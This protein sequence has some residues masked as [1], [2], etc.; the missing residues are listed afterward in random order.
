MRQEVVLV[1]EFDQPIGR[2]EKQQAHID[3]AL[4]RA[5]SIFIFN[6]AGQLLLQQRALHK[7]HSAGLWSNSCCSHPQ[8]DQP[9][10]E[11]ADQR[12]QEEMG[13]R[14]ELHK[15]FQ[16]TYKT[17]LEN[18]LTEHEVDH[19]LIG[20]FEGQPEPNSEEVKAYRWVSLPELNVALQQQPAH[21]SYWLKHCWPL[22]L[23]HLRLDPNKIIKQ[24]KLSPNMGQLDAH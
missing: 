7:Y 8:P 19:V 15:A 24:L 11:A 6:S 4:H 9:L 16:F 13:F 10:L 5:F 22:L 23:E 3:G 17:R 12:L 1:D 21:Y 14:C 20:T 2:A 18:G